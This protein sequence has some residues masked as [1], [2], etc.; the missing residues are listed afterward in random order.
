VK[1]SKINTGLL[2]LILVINAY[3]VLVPLAPAV[4]FRVENHGGKQRQLLNKVHSRTTAG[5]P[6]QVIVPSMLL[7][8]P[9]LEGPVS[10]AYP[11]LDKGIW[12]WPRGST[13]DKGGNTVLIGHRFTYTQ[14]RGSLYFLNKVAVG[15]LLAVIWNNRTYTYKV[16]AI[17]TVS[18]HDTSIENNTSDARLTIFTCTPLWLP[19]QRLVVVAN[20]EARP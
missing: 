3:I 2:I 8:Q 5:Q 7:D 10:Q 9:I 20:L 13:P 12:R 1:F 6:N 17:K 16:T 4:T 18:A 19:K 14:P 11:I 15:N